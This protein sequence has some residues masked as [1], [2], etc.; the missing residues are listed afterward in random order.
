ME[1]IQLVDMV[2]KR[3]IGGHEKL[4]VH[5]KF[6]NRLVQNIANMHDNKYINFFVNVETTLEEY[7]DYSITRISIIDT[8]LFFSIVY[9]CNVYKFYDSLG[10]D[11]YNIMFSENKN[12][13]KAV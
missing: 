9:D 8:L 5:R 7:K 13:V 10:M 6:L 11:C 4:K 12:Q 1:N 2:D 3:F